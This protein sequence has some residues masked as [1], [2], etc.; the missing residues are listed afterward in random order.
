[1]KTLIITCLIISVTCLSYAGYS[2]LGLALYEGSTKVHSERVTDEKGD[3]DVS[4]EDSFNWSTNDFLSILPT[5]EVKYIEPVWIKVTNT[6]KSVQFPCEE[7]DVYGVRLAAVSAS[8]RRI[9]GL[10]LSLYSNGRDERDG[11]IAGLQAA[12]YFNRAKS[13]KFGV[14]QLSLL[15]NSIYTGYID[16]GWGDESPKKN[17]LNKAI[18][19]KAIQI[20][21]ANITEDLLGFQVGIYNESYDLYGAQ[22]G[23]INVASGDAAGVQAGFMNF[24]DGTAGFQLGFFNYGESVRGFQLGLFNLADELKGIQIGLFNFCTRN[25]E[26]ALYPPVNIRF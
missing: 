7:S 1:M 24:A 5:N 6:V 21:C 10:S 19:N 25:S 13:S 23:L 16:T 3:D 12:T 15:H 26:L 4:Y 20:S 14:I 17:D 2:P 18:L 11:D 9:Y 22:V 8:N